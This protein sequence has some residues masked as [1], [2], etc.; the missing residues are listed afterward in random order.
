MAVQGLNHSEVKAV[1]D[2]LELSPSQHQGSSPILHGN[3]GKSGA[4][5][6][7]QHKESKFHGG[8]IKSA[9]F[10]HNAPKGKA[11]PYSK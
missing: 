6:P 8:K 9:K 1:C 11:T 2:N 4:Q 3:A 5:A 10:A 7:G